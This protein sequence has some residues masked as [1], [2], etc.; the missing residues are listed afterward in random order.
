MQNRAVLLELYKPR[1]GKNNTFSSALPAATRFEWC[2][3]IAC[4]LSLVL[5]W[6]LKLSGVS[7]S[8]ILS[9]IK[10]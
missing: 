4:I 8:A 6:V 3:D 5:F 9:E 2:S 10:D 7:Q 1:N